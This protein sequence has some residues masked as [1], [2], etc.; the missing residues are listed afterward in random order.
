M[1]KK[2]FFD[3]FVKKMIVK[4][5][6]SFFSDTLLLV[7]LP[8]LAMIMLYKKQHYLEREWSPSPAVRNEM[9]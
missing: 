4:R 7:H 6:L 2:N 3:F 5:H 9:H 8:T 1:E